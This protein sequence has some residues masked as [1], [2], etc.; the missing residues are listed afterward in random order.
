GCFDLSNPVSI[1]RNAPDAAAI[2]I[3]GGGTTAEI[4]SGDGTADPID[5]EIVGTGVGTNNGWLITDQ[6]TG[7]ILGLPAAPPFDLEGAGSGVC[8][9]W[10][11]RY[12]D[13]LTGLAAGN[14]VSDLMGCF[15]LSNPVSINRFTGTDCDA[16]SIDEFD[17]NFNI[18]I[19]PN[20]TKSN[21]NIEFEA[22]RAL[23]LDI[24]IIDML[25]KIVYR[26]NS[27]NQSALSFNISD[28]ENGTYFMNITDLE[29]GS[30]IVKR[31]IKN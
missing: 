9:I 13:G 6:A 30:R 8:D 29:S 26:N 3:V 15:D 24:Q 21:I 10:Y 16:L 28:L 31:V 2:Q 1:T 11:I 22:N 17:S 27:K 4:C 20:P 23:E 5:V 18:N 14:N 25:G 19:Y 12:E 7:E